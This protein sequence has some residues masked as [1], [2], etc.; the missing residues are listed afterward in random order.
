MLIVKPGAQKAH[1]EA[2]LVHDRLLHRV[3]M[4]ILLQPLDGADRAALH[5]VRQ[6]RAAVVGDAVE[7][8]R[9]RAR[10]PPGR[11]RAWCR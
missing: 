10:T 3:E 6:D 2:A 5:R 9:A 11:T 4:P 1:W 8:H 7:K